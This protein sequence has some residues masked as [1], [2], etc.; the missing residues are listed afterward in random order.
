MGWPRSRDKHLVQGRIAPSQATLGFL[1]GGI[2]YFSL[3]PGIMALDI[4]DSR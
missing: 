4:N 2:A 1:K 3:F